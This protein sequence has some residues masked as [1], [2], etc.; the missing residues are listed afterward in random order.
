[1]AMMYPCINVTDSRGLGFGVVAGIGEFGADTGALV[2]LWEL[3]CGYGRI[4]RIR[5]L[6]CGYGSFGADF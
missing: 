5:G 3:W 2:R 4:V 6:W 1:M